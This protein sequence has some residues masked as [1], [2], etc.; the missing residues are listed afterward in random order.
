[1]DFLL[2]DLLLL[3]ARDISEHFIFCRFTNGDDT[4]TSSTTSSTIGPTG[5]CNIFSCNIPIAF[6]TYFGTASLLAFYSNFNTLGSLIG[7]AIQTWLTLGGSGTQFVSNCL[8]NCL[9]TTMYYI[10][11]GAR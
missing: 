2:H 1:M 8:I 9:Y 5:L 6:T 11:S 4:G 7:D 10:A 3:I